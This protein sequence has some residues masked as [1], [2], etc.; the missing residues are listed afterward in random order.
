MKRQG[1]NVTVLS[2]TP[3]SVEILVFGGRTRLTHGTISATTLLILSELLLLL[4]IKKQLEE[5]YSD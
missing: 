3:T 4:V 2:S 1:H 5:H